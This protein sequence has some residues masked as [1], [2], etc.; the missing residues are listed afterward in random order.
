MGPGKVLFMIYR[1]RALP[2]L[3]GLLACAG[4]IPAQAA[5]TTTTVQVTGTVP[6][7]CSVTQLNPTVLSTTVPANGKLDPTLEGRNWAVPNVSCNS[8]TRISVTAKALR[9]NV[10]KTSLTPSQTQTI[11]F[12]ARASGWS[13]AAAA[14]TTR[15][16]APLGSGASYTGTAQVQPLAKSA[17]VTI[18]VSGFVPVTTQS[19]SAAKPVNGPYSATITLAIVP[20]V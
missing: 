9:L 18:T 15:E 4:A 17:M 1:I 13:T 8:P 2:A 3:A 12:T 14:V 7:G 19:N 10:P 20:N 5:P 16:T 6:N 11:N